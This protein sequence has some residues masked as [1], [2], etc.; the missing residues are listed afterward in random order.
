M[1]RSDKISVIEGKA[2][3]QVDEGIFFN[4]RMRGLRDISVVFLRALNAKDLSLLDCTAATGIR[5][6]RYAKEAGILRVTMLDINED[7][8]KNAKK[9]VKRNKVR[10]DVLGIG[11]Q[12]F[13]NNAKDKF[14]IID[15][16]P[17]GSPAPFIYDVLKLS[18]E[19]TV[20]M[21]TS[22]DTAVLC[23][24]HS[25]ACVKQYGSM[26][27]HNYLCKE[28]GI[29]ILI[30]HVIRK[31]A[32]FNFGVEVLFSISD[33]HYMRIFV[34]LQKGAKEAYSSMTSTGFGAQCSDCLFFKF[35]RGIVPDLGMKC[36]KCK[37]RMSNFG[38]VFLGDL[39]DKKII[40]KM[41]DDKGLEDK[42]TRKLVDTIYKEYETPFFYSLHK[43]TRMRHTMSVS[44]DAVSKHLSEKGYRTSRTQFDDNG[45]KTDASIE[46]VLAAVSKSRE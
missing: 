22:T 42:A 26:P 35:S 30:N 14:D 43:I 20:L 16:D 19:G 24:A 7:A 39:N 37:K 25:S 21:I 13:A 15:V 29:R 18:R 34:R 41:L 3:I 28:V 36:D 5:G 38:P 4:P 11:L 27:L 2:E 45:I 33:M 10:L 40:K 9:N 8:A 1:E 46:E 17:F 44:Y 6:I 23:G 32:E 31:A 12:D